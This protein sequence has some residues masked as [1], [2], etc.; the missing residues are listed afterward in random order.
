M[1]RWTDKLGGRKFIISVI[2]V[3]L[4][5]F[6][7]DVSGEAKLAFLGTVLGAYAAV[8]ASGKNGKPPTE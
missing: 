7:T 1:L 3:V 8:N 4:A 5:V 6:A 2:V